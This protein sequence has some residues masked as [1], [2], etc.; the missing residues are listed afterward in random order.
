MLD[1]V[2]MRGNHFSQMLI[3]ATSNWLLTLEWMYNWY[4][5]HKKSCFK[6]HYDLHWKDLEQLASLN[7]P[8]SFFHCSGNAKKCWWTIRSKYIWSCLALPWSWFEAVTTWSWTSCN[9]SGALLPYVLLQVLY[10]M[11]FT[12][13]W[14]PVLIWWLLDAFCLYLS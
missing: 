11:H 3:K 12:R 4:Y 9:Q 13:Q 1:P 14:L 7:A 10:Y 2:M 5:H 6:F 8:A